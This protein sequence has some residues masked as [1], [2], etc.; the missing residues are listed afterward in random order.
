MDHIVNA[1]AVNLT[2]NVKQGCPVTDYTGSY[3][4]T[5]VL[6]S[7]ITTHIPS[8]LSTSELLNLCLIV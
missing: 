6:M 2:G 3:T 1:D 8:S 5:S 4:M 7:N